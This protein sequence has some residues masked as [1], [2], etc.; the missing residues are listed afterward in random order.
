MLNPSQQLPLVK[1]DVVHQIV[2]EVRPVTAKNRRLD[3]ARLEAAKREFRDLEKQGIMRRSSI[4]WASHLHIVKKSDGS[5]RPCGDFRLLNLITKPKLYTCPIIGDLTSR[6][7]GCQIFSKLDQ[8][9]LTSG[10]SEASR[11]GQDGHHHAFRPLGV[12]KDAI[13]PS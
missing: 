3:A 13:R 2:T 11:C 10:A 7:V 6:L 12:F 1:Q 9:G 5:W 4:N 8:K